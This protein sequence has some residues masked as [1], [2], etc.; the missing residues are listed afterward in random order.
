MSHALVKE[1]TSWVGGEPPA[2]ATVAVGAAVPTVQSTVG[3]PP[4]KNPE[5]KVIVMALAVE[6]AEYA[7][8]RVKPTS[9]T[10]S[11]LAALFG[12]R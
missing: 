4:V 6:A 5:G 1:R 2:K 7:V 8:S 3:V 9:T 12:V 11:V 10:A